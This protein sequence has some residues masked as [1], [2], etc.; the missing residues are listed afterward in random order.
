[1]VAWRAPADFMA[2]LRTNVV[3]PFLVRVVIKG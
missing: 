1:M 3:D 2:W